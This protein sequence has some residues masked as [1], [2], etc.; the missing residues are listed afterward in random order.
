MQKSYLLWPYLKEYKANITRAFKEE[1]AYFVELD[2]TIFYP[3][4]S[5]GQPEDHGQIDGIHVIHVRENQGVIE[6]Q[7]TEEMQEG[8]VTMQLDWD[9]R[10][11]HMQQHT[12]QHILSGI[13]DQLFG[14][15]TVGFMIGEQISTIDID[16]VGRHN[17]LELVHSV[18]ELANRLCQSALPIHRSIAKNADPKKAEKAAGAPIRLIHIPTI[19]VTECGGT[20]VAN[21]CECGPIRI[22]KTQKDRGH[23]RVTYIAGKRCLREYDSLQAVA[24]QWAERYNT[25]AADAFKRVQTQIDRIDVLEK[26]NKNLIR[27]TMEALRPALL[28]KT[29]SHRGYQALVQYINAPLPL[30]DLAKDLPQELI[31]LVNSEGALYVK[32]KQPIE[33]VTAYMETLRADEN[34][35]GG[36]KGTEWY[37][38][39]LEG[40]YATLP[41][42]LWK[43][44][45]NRW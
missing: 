32:M 30:R 17:A 10:Y 28:V 43:E 12:A 21:T 42:T 36:G 1:D 33:A 19:A 9:R 37:G 18:C 23:L 41:E 5:G 31:L 39:F 8:P 14:I 44:M 11:D 6:H 34:F 7:V 40:P 3:H 24:E 2:Q 15:K 13:F 29:Q 25:S 26:E 35:K 16:A 22:V 45:T 20:H 38:Q 4:L 27:L